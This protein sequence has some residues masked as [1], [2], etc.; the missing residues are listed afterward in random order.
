V[1]EYKPIDE[2][3]QVTRDNFNSV[4]HAYP[5][6]PVVITE[7]GWT[8]NT[9]GR[10]IL[11]GNACEQ[12]Q[13]TYYHAL[14]EWSEKENIL[15][16]FFEAFDESWKGSAEPMEPEKHWGLFTVDRKPKKVMQPFFPG[17]D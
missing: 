10:G 1:W 8:T 9:N 5:G 16:F 17:L 4:A 13:E 15:T 12:R 3:M 11:P 2:A 14:H 6:K 7:A